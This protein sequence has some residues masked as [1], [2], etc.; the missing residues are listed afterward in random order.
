M[1]FNNFLYRQRQR[2]QY[3]VSRSATG[4]RIAEIN[5]YKR[6]IG[7]EPNGYWIYEL[8]TLLPKGRFDFVLQPYVFDLFLLIARRLQGK[9]RVVNGHLFFEFDDLRI[10]ITN[11]SELHIIH[12][13]YVQRCYHFVLPDNETVQVIDIGMNVGLASLFFAGLPYVRRVHAFEP[14]A[15][16]FRQAEKNLLGNAARAAKIEIHNFGLGFRHE[17]IS[18]RYN[19][20]NPGINSCS[21]GGQ[22]ASVD[23]SEWLNIRPADETIHSI[24]DLYPNEKFILKIDTEGSEYSIFESLFRQELS[25]QVKGIMLEWHFNGFKR[26]EEPLLKSGFMLTSFSLG[27]DSGLI[28]AF[29]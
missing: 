5:R 7:V 14:F 4:K 16:T 2:I 15:R 29:R 27:P 22:E 19:F 21:V 10:E 25:R 9:Y 20:E 8:Q 18:A 13:I 28:Y 23:G 17:R 26:L 12:E 3:H 24:F 1:P 6:T 11:K